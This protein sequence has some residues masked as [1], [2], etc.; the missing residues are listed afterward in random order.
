MAEIDL[1]GVFDIDH[2]KS[3]NVANES[4]C[5]AY[6]DM[7]ALLKVV[8]AVSI[9]VPTDH[10]HAVGMQVLNSGLHCLIEKPI[11]QN[12]NEADDL[13][14]MAKNNGLVLHVG[15]IERFNPAIRA[16]KDMPMNP[17]F[18]ESHRLAPFNPRG[19]EVAVVLD[20]MIHDIDI[21]LRYVKSPIQKVDASGIAVVS[22]TVDIA[23]VRLNFENG[24]VSNMTASRIS[25]KK[26]RKMRIFQ[27]NEYVSVDFLDKITEI[28]QLKKCGDPSENVICEMGVGEKK[29][30]VV[31]RKPDVPKEGGLQVELESFLQAVRGGESSGVTGREGRESLA[32][33]MNILDQL[34]N[35]KNPI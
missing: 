1:V 29:Q 19:T 7:G 35:Q 18:I 15:H 16:I 3:R 4:G 17:L 27:K 6:E 31:Y 12:L 9:A 28:F 22:D 10:H 34:K 13:I 32:V 25:Q 8:D 33:A 2:E 26:M 21:I 23:N 30:C 20:L 5:K 14:H 11:A 24:C